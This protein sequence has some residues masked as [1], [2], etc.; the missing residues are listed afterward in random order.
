MAK[1]KTVGKL[2]KELQVIVN[3]YIRLRDEGKPCI[4]C[5][6]YNTLQAG[7]FFAVGGYDG[8]RFD[9]DNIHGECARCN[10]WDESH[11]IL[12]ADNLKSKIGEHDFNALKQR[13]ADYKRN[14]YKFSRPE[15]LELIE[16]YK[17]KVRI[18][19]NNN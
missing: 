17:K 11:L 14:G 4:S 10:C 16:I 3:Q 5:G 6:S 19:K 13:A 9:E 18:L 15:L 2:K 12:Y 8:L 1:T 7:H